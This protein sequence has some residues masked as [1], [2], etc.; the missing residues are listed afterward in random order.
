[1]SVD[2]VGIASS[3]VIIVLILLFVL[4]E[5]MAL[6]ALS[7]NLKKSVLMESL[8]RVVSRRKWM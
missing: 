1:M 6:P 7:D 4:M 3:I 2:A 8:I 5:H